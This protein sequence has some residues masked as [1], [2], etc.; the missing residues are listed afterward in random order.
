V[1]KQWRSTRTWP[2]EIKM[3]NGVEEDAGNWVA[4]I[5]GRMPR[6]EVAGDISLSRPR[7]TQGGRADDDDD[8]TLRKLK[9]QIEIKNIFSIKFS[10]AEC[11][12]EL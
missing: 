8:I 6:I 9:T 3:N 10:K 2:T 1:D 12:V 11:R 4:E 7:S 5:G